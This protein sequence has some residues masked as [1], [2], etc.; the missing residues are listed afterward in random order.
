MGGGVFFQ[1]LFQESFIMHIHRLIITTVI[2]F[3]ANWN[4]VKSICLQFQIGFSFNILS[5]PTAPRV[6]SV[7]CISANFLSPFPYFCDNNICIFFINL[8]IFLSPFPYFCNNNLYI[9]S[10]NLQIFL[11]PFMY[12]CDNNLCIFFI[13]LTHLLIRT[14]KQCLLP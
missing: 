8:Q 2:F 11:S 9:S 14:S 3:I 12:F 4:G 1:F 7:P 6:R 10:I 5:L 13:N